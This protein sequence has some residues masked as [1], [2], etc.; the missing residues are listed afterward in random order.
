MILADFCDPALVQ[1]AHA[2]GVGARLD[3]TLGGQAQPRLRHAAGGTGAGAWAQ[4]RQLRQPGAERKALA[5]NCGPGAL[6]DVQ[7]I[8]VV[9]TSA[10]LPANDPAFFAH[11][12]IDLAATRLLREERK[13][14]FHAA[15]EPRCAAIIEVDAPGPAMADLSQL[16]FA[17][18]PAPSPAAP[19]WRLAQ[20]LRDRPRCV[21]YRRG[22]RAYRHAAV[23]HDVRAGDEPAASLAR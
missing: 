16:P 8:G 12:G 19:R 15:F 7:G 18:W 22:A 13:N 2:G 4:R 10:V 1:R 21:R 11:H 3:A 6:L 14:H 9:V 23:H 5:R 17:H 20:R